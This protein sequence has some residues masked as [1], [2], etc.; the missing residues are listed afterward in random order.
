MT[1]TPEAV[2]NQVVKVRQPTDIEV[3]RGVAVDRV[4]RGGSLA[5]FGFGIGL[6][7]DAL[8]LTGLPLSVALGTAFT[9]LGVGTVWAGLGAKHLI[10]YGRRGSPL[11]LLSLAGF[12][13]S[14]LLRVVTGYLLTAGPSAV[15]NALSAV[16]LAG[17]LGFGLILVLLTLV[18]L[19]KILLR[20]RDQE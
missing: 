17:T 1:Q 16:A 7:A 18:A 4:F 19:V 2:D 15:L 3:S 6:V 20:S 14:I 8:N 12:G 5:L 13:G 10:R 11:A 9:S